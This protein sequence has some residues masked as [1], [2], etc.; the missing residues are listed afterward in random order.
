M[1]FFSL[2]ISIYNINLFNTVRSLHVVLLIFLLS[3]AIYLRRKLLRELENSTIIKMVR[4]SKKKKGL[5]FRK[6]LN[7]KIQESVVQEK[8]I[9]ITHIFIIIIQKTLIIINGIT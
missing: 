6:F 1:F 9:Y 3:K 8:K 4:Y 7:R 2:S 5:L